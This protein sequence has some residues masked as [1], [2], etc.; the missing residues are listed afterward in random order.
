KAL[1][2]LHPTVRQSMLELEVLETSSLR[3]LIQTSE[4]LEA[5]HRMGI[6]IALDDFGTGYSTLSYL[7][8]L[9]A[10]TLKIDRSFVGAM[11]ESHED[12]AIIEGILGLAKVFD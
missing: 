12:R 1:L 3:D 9:P 4:V 2:D 7:K 8:R 10:R 11:L 5:C 6:E